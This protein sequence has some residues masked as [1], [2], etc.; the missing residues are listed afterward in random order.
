LTYP[1]AT[2]AVLAPISLVVLGRLV[3]T[4]GSIPLAVAVA[5][6]LAGLAATMSRAGALALVVG[7]VVLTGRQG[8]V[9]PRGPRPA[10]WPAPW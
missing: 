6:L 2:A 5:G 1:N 10:R 7:L 9:R 4:P 3:A 8:W